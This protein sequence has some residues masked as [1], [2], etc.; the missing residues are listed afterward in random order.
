MTEENKVPDEI[1]EKTVIALQKHERK[2]LSNAR[3]QLKNQLVELKVKQNQ[4]QNSID[5]LA[6]LL[7][8]LDK[9]FVST[10]RK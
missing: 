3:K 5:E 4:L 2:A 1:E 9:V 10:E 7:N 8:S 6:A